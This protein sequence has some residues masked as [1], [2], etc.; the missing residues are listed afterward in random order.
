MPKPIDERDAGPYDPLSVI[1]A[2]GCGFHD[3]AALE[4]I[5]RWVENGNVDDLRKAIRYLCR[6]AA[7]D[8]Y[9]TATIRGV[10]TRGE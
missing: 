6:L 10:R 1:E 7:L 5:H 9:A 3:G 2:W 8:K 4:C